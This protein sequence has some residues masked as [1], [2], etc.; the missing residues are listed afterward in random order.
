MKSSYKK[1]INDISLVNFDSIND[2]LKEANIKPLRI[3]NFQLDEDGHSPKQLKLSP[4]L[5][6]NKEPFDN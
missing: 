5:N 6:T 1:F 3:E 4:Y 2:K